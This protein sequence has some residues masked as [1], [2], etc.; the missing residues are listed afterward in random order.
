M[1]LYILFIYYLYITLP[2][3][4][5]T[6]SYFYVPLAPRE[7]PMNEIMTD[8]VHIQ[9]RRVKCLSNIKKRIFYIKYIK[10]ILF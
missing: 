6:V 9:S 4:D 8:N 1:H 2:A 7:G 5:I 3:D 10:I